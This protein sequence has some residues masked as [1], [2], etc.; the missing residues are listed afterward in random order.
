MQNTVNYIV[1]DLELAK[2]IR[3]NLHLKKQTDETAFSVYSNKEKSRCLI[4]SEQQPEKIVAATTYSYSLTKPCLMS[5]IDSSVLSLDKLCLVDLLEDR[6]KKKNYY[7]FIHHRCQLPSRGFKSPDQ[8][9][10]KL[11]AF[12]ETAANFLTQEAISMA[13]ANVND[14]E[15]FN[16]IKVIETNIKLLANLNT[17]EQQSKPVLEKYIQ[18]C[19]RHY[20]FTQYQLIQLRYLLQRGI[21][22]LPEQEIDELLIGNK[23]TKLLLTQLEHKL[24]Q[25][26][27]FWG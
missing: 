16:L 22:H 27:Y 25:T 4:I 14:I 12:Y 23:P 8:L 5:Y 9:T 2:H 24:E 6:R 26:S 3:K 19:Q 21:I 18:R 20:S 10:A 17:F 7:P 11:S 13:I 1:A 15:N